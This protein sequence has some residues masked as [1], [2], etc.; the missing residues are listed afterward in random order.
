MQ[1][2]I[3]IRQLALCRSMVQLRV[4]GT[5]RACRAVATLSIMVPSLPFAYH[6]R[7]PLTATLYEETRLTVVNIRRIVALCERARH[8]ALVE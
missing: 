3:N 8:L 7:L 1:T 6:K 4:G 2:R 5:E